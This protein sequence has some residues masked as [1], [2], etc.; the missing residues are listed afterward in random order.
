MKTF[1][2]TFSTASVFIAVVSLM[3]FSCQKGFKASS[4]APPKPPP[5]YNGY[6]RSQDIY[7]TNLIAYWPFNGNLTDSLSQTAGTATGTSFSA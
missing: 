2:Y 1:K 3:L 6:S 4:Y 5:T 7:P